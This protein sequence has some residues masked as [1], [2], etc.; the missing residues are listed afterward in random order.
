MIK[1]YA[2][3]SDLVEMRYQASIQ[4]GFQEAFSSMFPAP[5]QRHLDAMALSE[6]ELRNHS[7]PCI[8]NSWTR[9]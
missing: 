5:R 3:N 2:I 8:I 4:E 9:G 1:V 7:G 6:D